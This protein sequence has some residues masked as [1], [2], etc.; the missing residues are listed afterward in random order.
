MHV[1][2]LQNSPLG[3]QISG[4][5]VQ[6]QVFECKAEL[7]ILAQ[8]REKNGSQNVI[9]LC[10]RDIVSSLDNQK[11]KRKRKKK[12]RG[13]LDFHIFLPIEFLY[14]NA[15]Y[16]SHFFSKLDDKNE[17]K[18]DPEKKKKKEKD[19]EKKKKEE[20]NKDKKEEW[21]FILALKLGINLWWV[22]NPGII[23]LY[24]IVKRPYVKTKEVVIKCEFKFVSYF[25][26]IN[27]GSLILSFIIKNF[28]SCHWL[29]SP[30]TDEDK[31]MTG[32]YL[33]SKENWVPRDLTII[34]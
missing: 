4:F 5:W 30:S 23:S 12:R 26:K 13:K 10:D 21:V 31:L 25:L 16:I 1:Q 22:L 17:N 34:F 29:L 20:K 7:R 2:F 3:N 33:G 14:F 8:W 18:K 27:N 28:Y 15:N 19:K 9:W 32:V 6:V 11:K 24:F